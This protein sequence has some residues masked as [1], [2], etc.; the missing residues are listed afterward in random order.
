VGKLAEGGTTADV[1][2]LSL[3][4]FENIGNLEFYSSCFNEGMR[5]QPAVLLT[6]TISFTK[7][8]TLDWLKVREGD[9]FFIDIG[10]IHH[11]PTEWREPDRFIPD[12]FDSKSKYFLTPAGKPRNPFSFMPFLGGQ[13]ICI[14]KTFIDSASKIIV[15]TLLTHFDMDFIDGIDPEKFQL[16]PNSMS[17]TF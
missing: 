2:Y 9:C 14:G 4:N 3:V 8:C 17:S 15:P 10:R 12:R 1:D 7:D 11:N 16:P 5:Y 6:S 13:R